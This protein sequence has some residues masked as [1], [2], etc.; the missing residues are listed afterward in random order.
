[1]TDINRIKWDR[2]IYRPVRRRGQGPM[3]KRR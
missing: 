1:M 3:R 2:F